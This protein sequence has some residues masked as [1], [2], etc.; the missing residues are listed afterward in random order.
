M[1]SVATISSIIILSKIIVLTLL[2][3]VNSNAPS[4][5]GEGWDGVILFAGVDRAAERV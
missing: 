2:E 4:L 1:N 3:E 5:E